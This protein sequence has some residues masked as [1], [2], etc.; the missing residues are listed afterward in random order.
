MSAASAAELDMNP[1]APLPLANKRLAPT[2]DNVAT[3]K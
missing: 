3:T 2:V 1:N